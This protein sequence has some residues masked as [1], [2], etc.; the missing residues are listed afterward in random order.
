MN[1][2]ECGGEDVLGGETV[3]GCDDYEACALGEG[4][5]GWCVVVG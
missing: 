4:D 3:G 5:E 1:I 2:V